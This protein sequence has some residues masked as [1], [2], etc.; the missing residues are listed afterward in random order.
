MQAIRN[1]LGVIL[2]FTI[3]LIASCITFN[4]RSDFKNYNY[5]N[6]MFAEDISL[7][8]GLKIYAAPK[9]INRQN[10]LLL[11]FKKDTLKYIISNDW[12]HRI[13]YRYK[14]VEDSI[15]TLDVEKIKRFDRGGSYEILD[16][17]VACKNIIIKKNVVLS[18]RRSTWNNTA[19][20]VYVK[21]ENTILKYN[22]KEISNKIETA[23]ISTKSIIQ[24]FQQNKMIVSDSIQFVLKENIQ[25]TTEIEQQFFRKNIMQFRNTKK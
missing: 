23:T 2:F 20:D 8:D 3:V 12:S 10:E 22:L 13:R 25:L 7:F 15:H 14:L 18:S 11:F 4:N 24:L 5:D 16:S 6:E 21:K 19:I 17:I 9:N 1:Q